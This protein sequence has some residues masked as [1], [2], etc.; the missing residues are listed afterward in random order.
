MNGL[1]FLG[2]YSKDAVIN[3]LLGHT[4]PMRV[5]AFLQIFGVTYYQANAWAGA[6]FTLTKQK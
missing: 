4:D 2:A 6:A 3:L 1:F 5:I